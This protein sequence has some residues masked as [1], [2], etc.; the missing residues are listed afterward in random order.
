MVEP[1]PRFVNQ[2]WCSAL[3]WSPPWLYIHRRNPKGFFS[4]L[5]PENWALL[6][7]R[8]QPRR[9]DFSALIGKR[10]VPSFLQKLSSSS[11]LFWL[12]NGGKLLVFIPESKFLFVFAGNCATFYEVR[13]RSDEEGLFHLQLCPGFAFCELNWLFWV[14]GR[15]DM[16]ILLALSNR[17]CS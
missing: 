9:L 17:W 3:L 5:R 13:I 1:L 2:R 15:N 16:W 6:A 12:W 10:L 8:S 14:G 11:F 4:L 7:R